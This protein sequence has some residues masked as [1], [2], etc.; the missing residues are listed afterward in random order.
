MVYGWGLYGRVDRVPGLF[1][2]A[3]QFL[4]V[5]FFPVYPSQS[6]LVI[7]RAEAA[8]GPTAVKLEL[9]MKSIAMA[10]L[11]AL[12]VAAGLG[13]SFFGTIAALRI[14]ESPWFWLFPALGVGCLALWWVRRGAGA[15]TPERAMELG[16]LAGIHVD[17]VARATLGR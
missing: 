13:L 2:V 8:A 16:A 3:T 4:H 7:E 15:A 9:N 10:Y 1:F 5:S 6:Y 17:T 14:E 11:K 12:L